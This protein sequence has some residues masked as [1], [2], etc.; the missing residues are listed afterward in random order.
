ML[1]DT[2]ASK[3]QEESN[4]KNCRGLKQD[5]QGKNIIYEIKS[6]VDW[7]WSYGKESP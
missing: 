2:C 3:S 4:F 5:C 7:I 6:G 1:F